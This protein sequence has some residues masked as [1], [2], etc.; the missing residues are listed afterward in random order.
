[1]AGFFCRPINSQTT[2]FNRE[3]AVN[4]SWYPDPVDWKNK[5]DIATPAPGCLVRDWQDALESWRQSCHQESLV[6]SNRPSREED[7]AWLKTHVITSKALAENRSW[8]PSR[9][10]WE[11][12]EEL[13]SEGAESNGLLEFW[14]YFL[15][16]WREDRADEGMLPESEKPTPDD[17]IVWLK[18][19]VLEAGPALLPPPKVVTVKELLNQ[20]EDLKLR[21]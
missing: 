4:T 19:R 12:E 2:V 20:C 18:A 15:K 1:M 10:G 14:V 6:Q 21:A 13:R 9:E 11:Q 8:Y 3:A 7:I 17:D 16:S 5:T